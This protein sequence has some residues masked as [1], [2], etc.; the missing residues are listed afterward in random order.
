MLRTL[1]DPTVVDAISDGFFPDFSMREVAMF[2]DITLAEAEQFTPSVVAE[3][4][5]RIKAV[6]PWWVAYRIRL[7]AAAKNAV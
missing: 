2:C 5:D 4:I 7:F 3:L 1:S 6:N